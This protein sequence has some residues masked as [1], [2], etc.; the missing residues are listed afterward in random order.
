MEARELDGWVRIVEM[1][2]IIDVVERYGC[3]GKHV[4]CGGILD[5]QLRCDMSCVDEDRFP[6]FYAIAKTMEDLI[7]RWVLEVPSRCLRQS[8]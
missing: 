6:A 5:A 1:M 3:G 8:A 7:P 2:P 4:K